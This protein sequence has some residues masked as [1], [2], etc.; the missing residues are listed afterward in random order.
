MGTCY[1]SPICGGWSPT[2]YWRLW[3]TRPCRTAMGDRRTC[4]LWH[5]FR[6]QPCPPGR[7][8]MRSSHPGPGATEQQSSSPMHPPRPRW[9]G[10]G[11]RFRAHIQRRRTRQQGRFLSQFVSTCVRAEQQ[12][13]RDGR[14]TLGKR[15][16]Q[17]VGDGQAGCATTG[18]DEVILGSELRDLPFDCR[19][20]RSTREPGDGRDE[21]NDGTRQQHGCLDALQ[22]N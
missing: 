17:P 18:D 15:F 20:R 2:R 1:S 19:M 21:S 7:K 3:T 13:L 11:Q 14:L 9:P 10:V 12:R 22:L 6:Q 8:P 4:H 16:G 5:C